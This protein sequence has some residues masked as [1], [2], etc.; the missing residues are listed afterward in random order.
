VVKND[1]KTVQM[2]K[3]NGKIANGKLAN[4]RSA[5]YRSIASVAVK[6]HSATTMKTK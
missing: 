4:N 3:T 5:D 1:L 6:K 2:K